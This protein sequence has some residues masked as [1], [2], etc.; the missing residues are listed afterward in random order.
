M[1][2]PKIKRLLCGAS[3]TLLC[4]SGLDD[5]PPRGRATYRPG[6]AFERAIHQRFDRWLIQIRR[7]FE[8]DV[9]DLLTAAFQQLLRIG[10]IHAAEEK[11]ADPSRIQRDRKDHIRCALRRAE[12][13]G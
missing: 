13:D 6:G 2:P 12:S 4:R 3:W 7:A 9:P 8:N 1:Y 10:K 11:K 5:D